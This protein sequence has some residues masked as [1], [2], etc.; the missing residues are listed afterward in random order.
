MLTPVSFLKRSSAALEEGYV[1]SVI[2]A[3]RRHK[4][5]NLRSLTLLAPFVSPM[6]RSTQMTD[7]LYTSNVLSFL[8]ERPLAAAGKLEKSKHGC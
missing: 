2:D 8:N 5:S 4:S 7:T 1:Y 6:P 3:T